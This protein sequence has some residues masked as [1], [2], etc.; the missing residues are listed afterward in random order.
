MARMK[1][2]MEEVQNRINEIG[3]DIEVLEWL[4]TNNPAKYK[5]NTCDHIN[6][7]KIGQYLY[8]PNKDRYYEFIEECLVCHYEEKEERD[9]KESLELSKIFKE[10]EA[11]KKEK[12]KEEEAYKNSD[13]YKAKS[14]EEA[15][16]RKRAEEAQAIERKKMYEEILKQREEMERVKQK[17]IENF[18]LD[19]ELR[20]YHCKE[21][22]DLAKNG[23]DINLKVVEFHKILER[24]GYK[25]EIEKREKNKKYYIVTR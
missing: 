2:T 14:I 22:Q 20:E 7:I 4:G 16:K 23:L 11:R 1:L 9:L 25:F 18:K 19:I 17:H 8:M 5:F 15:R 6:E 13:E 24:N 3:R 10:E 12:E 21:L